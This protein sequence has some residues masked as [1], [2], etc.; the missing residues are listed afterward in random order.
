MD[1]LLPL[2]QCSV[3]YS[4]NV[5]YFSVFK[6][7]SLDSYEFKSTILDFFA[8]DP[9][10]TRRLN[11]VDWD[12]WFYSPG[13]PPKPEFDT[14]LVDIVYELAEKWKSLSSSSPSFTPSK[15]DIKGL[16]A[17]QF[18]VFLERVTLFENPA[19]SSNSF[20]LMGQVYGF[21]DSSNIEV[22]NL[23]FRL[24]LKIGDKSAI[25]P[26]VKLLGEIGRMKFVRPL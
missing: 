24:G 2:T 21:A 11:D 18:I 19:L 14:S 9:V 3:K 7:K 25:E 8:N 13:L 12:S 5:Q 26:A 15:E 16:S 1:S 4:N 17:N 22:T 10:A 23:Y 6:E 20:R